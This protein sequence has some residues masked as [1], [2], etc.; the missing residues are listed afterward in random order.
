MYIIRGSLETQV[1]QRFKK[2]TFERIFTDLSYCCLLWFAALSCSQWRT[3]SAWH[4]HECCNNMSYT[5]GESGKIQF[6]WYLGVLTTSV[7][8]IYY[9]AYFKSVTIDLLS[10]KI[11]VHDKKLHSLFT[12]VA[13]LLYFI[14]FL[15]CYY[16]KM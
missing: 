9:C 13:R 7:D 11:F 12:E 5:G 2:N 4:K 10:Q 15:K 1:K 14:P 8:S 3:L 16:K 6:T